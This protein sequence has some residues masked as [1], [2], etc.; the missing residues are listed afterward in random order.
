[1]YKIRLAKWGLFKNKSK[2]RAPPK[3]KAVAGAGAKA[4]EVE[5]TEDLD[6][7]ADV[8]VDLDADVDSD[9][10]AKDPASSRRRANLRGSSSCAQRTAEECSTRTRR[11]RR[12]QRA[13]CSSVPSPP[14]PAQVAPNN[15]RIQVPK[16]L[17]DTARD[18]RTYSAFSKVRAWGP[19]EAGLEKFL[20]SLRREDLD[21]T[22]ADDLASTEMYR[23]FGLA[24]ALWG[25][26]QGRLA[27]KAVRKAFLLVEEAVTSTD[28]MLMWNVV[29]VVYE[30]VHWGQA[31]L[32]RVFLDYVERMAACK[33]PDHPIR[34]V[35]RC[36]A[37]ESERG[38]EAD[39]YEVV[40]RVWRCHLDQLRVMLRAEED[41]VKTLIDNV[42]LAEAKLGYGDDGQPSGGLI[43]KGIREWIRTAELLRRSIRPEHPYTPEPGQDRWETRVWYITVASFIA[44]STATDNTRLKRWGGKATVRQ[45]YG[46]PSYIKDKTLRSRSPSPS[47]SSPASSNSSSNDSSSSSSSSSGSSGKLDVYPDIYVR[48]A[49]LR[50]LVEDEELDKAEELATIVVQTTDSTQTADGLR[51]IVTRW[52]F[53]DLLERVGK[54]EQARAIREENIRRIEDFLADIPDQLPWIDR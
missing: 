25:R 22:V 1:M 49:V 53:E 38:S 39:L 31:A 5:E 4:S 54:T 26:G 8:D 14:Q 17:P 35:V 15:N 23:S 36:L 21:R 41:K 37:A 34:T 33:V 19:R 11:R 10:D 20:L 18:M 52:A 13:P 47:P 12:R 27:G 51:A 2:K 9:L 45:S 30:M 46:F 7:D 28:T 44:W 40:E 50:A 3:T 6:A 29:D 24:A 43:A 48:K 32:L 42:S 16:R